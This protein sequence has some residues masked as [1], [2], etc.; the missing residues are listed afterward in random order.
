MFNP[1]NKKRI[2]TLF[3]IAAIAFVILFAIVN[4][5]AISSF[6]GAV[7]SV[8]SPILI[9]AGIAY[10]LNP[11]LKLYEFKIFKKIKNKKVL[12]GLSLF[13]TFFTVVV[14][15]TGF[16]FIFIPALI[17]S[18]SS[19]IGNMDDYL[20]KATDFINRSLSKFSKNNTINEHVDRDSL[21]S[22]ITGL[23]TESGKL[24]DVILG[25]VK[26]LG[27]SLVEGVKTM[28]LA[29]FIAVYILISKERLGAQFCKLTVAFLPGK[30]R[31]TM[32]RYLRLANRTFGDYFIGVILDAI[33]V[34]VFSLVVFLIFGIPHALF[35]SVVIG[36]TNIIPIFGP[37]IGGIPSFFI[38]FLA[39]PKKA[40]LFAILIFVIQQIDGN[41][42]AP[43]IHSTSTMLSSLGVIVAIT[44]MGAYFGIA[45]M[46]IGVPVFSMLVA[47]CKEIIEKRLKKAG[48]PTDTAEYY[49]HDS[50]VDPHETHERYH[51]RLAKATTKLLRTILRIF[52]KKKSSP[53]ADAHADT[54]DP[55]KETNQKNE[56]KKD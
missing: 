26:T 25:Y 15:I 33:F 13:M 16:L 27:L 55:Q 19:L 14:V 2:I 18:I 6:F 46:I 40:I 43:K 48:L 11:L 30:A 17:D 23:F 45:G 47:I 22:G 38:I 52:K 4:I 50:L 41:I 21:I 56:E 49:T 34:M 7:V 1:D 54:S 51:T 12:R 24:F 31:L 36:V 44:I 29:I 53:A 42:I 5:Q 32:R 28:I 10:L 9:G 37:F 8:F 20:N 3:L 39:S 35:I